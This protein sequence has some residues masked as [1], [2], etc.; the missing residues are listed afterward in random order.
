LKWN[1]LLADPELID[2]VKAGIIE[3]YF[4]VLYQLFWRAAAYSNH[5]D[6]KDVRH[7]QTSYSNA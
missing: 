2:K 3:G 4:L 6:E 5:T 1:S 7:V